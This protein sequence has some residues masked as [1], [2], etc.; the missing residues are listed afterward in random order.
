MEKHRKLMIGQRVVTPQNYLNLCVA[1]APKDS[2]SKGK[3]VETTESLD[4]EMEEGLGR[5]SEH[6]SSSGS[7]SPNSEAVGRERLL[8]SDGVFFD[9][10]QTMESTL[11]SNEP[12]TAWSLSNIPQR[13]SPYQ[14]IGDAELDPFSILRLSRD[15][16]H[17]LHHWIHTYSP[18]A[19]GAPTDPVFEP[20]RNLFAAVDLAQ[21]ACVHATLAHAAS[22]IAFL[23]QER[24]D[25]IQAITHK[26]AAMRIINQSL[27][28]PVEAISDETF[29]AVLRLLAFERYW[30]TEPAWRLHR[31][32]LTQML[33][34][35]GGLSTFQSNWKLELRIHLPRWNKPAFTSPE[36]I[37]EDSSTSE[38]TFNVLQDYELPHSN[39]VNFF[40]DITTINQ[41]MVG[42]YPSVE[43]AVTFLRSSSEQPH[44]KIARVMCLFYIAIIFK[45]AHRSHFDLSWLNDSL[46]MTEQIWS[47]SVE[48][49]RW[50]LLQGMGRGPEV[51]ESL[52]RTEKLAEVARLLKEN[53]WRRLEDRYSNLLL[54]GTPN[55]NENAPWN[56]NIF[57][58]GD[59]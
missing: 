30:G 41:D 57:G 18:E 15:D 51:P 7:E 3:E 6:F 54:D 40:S 43:K 39:F 17:L 59:D 55:G 8:S 33:Q 10:R 48:T 27:S 29:S 21:S 22:H 50:M 12:F 14:S 11:G 4:V 20:I 2:S 56:S 46:S 13:P 44:Q 34:K 26:M 52:A 16:K 58:R 1:R 32:G 53:S 5:R 23:R 38:N 35:R 36:Q 49:L 24:S 9:L 42:Q 31:K 28:D 45:H 19:Y 47:N 37:I 25:S